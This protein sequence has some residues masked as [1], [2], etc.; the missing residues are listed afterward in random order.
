MRRHEFSFCKNGFKINLLETTRRNTIFLFHCWISFAILKNLRNF[1]ENRSF[2]FRVIH[3][4]SVKI[5]TFFVNF[6]V[7]DGSVK[8]LSYH[9]L[10]SVINEIAN[11]KYRIIFLRQV[12][13]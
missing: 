13:F 11:I 8:G 1:K 4:Y 10:R 2:R 9:N 12:C 7:I 3:C 6:L 5:R